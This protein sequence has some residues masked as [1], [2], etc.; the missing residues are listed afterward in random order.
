MQLEIKKKIMNKLF[1]RIS[2][3]KINTRKGMDILS[4]ILDMTRIG[5]FLYF[6]KIIFFYFFI[7]FKLIFFN[8]FISF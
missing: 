6:K 3:T 7:C 1:R 8:I 5:L 4:Y 2:S